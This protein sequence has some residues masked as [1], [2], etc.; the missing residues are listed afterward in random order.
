[1]NLI[2]EPGIYEIIPKAIAEKNG[3]F[4]VKEIA[5]LAAISTR[6]IIGGWPVAPL[7]PLL[8]DKNV[9]LVT[10]LNTPI[11]A[12]YAQTEPR[13]T[14]AARVTATPLD[15]QRA[16]VAPRSFKI[17]WS[18][19]KIAGNRVVRNPTANCFDMLH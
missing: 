19:D 10:K 8:K 13:I 2:V 15:A 1:V 16:G 9:T 3:L 11:I 14:N 12:L 17:K 6:E 5:R 7:G 4:P 18:R